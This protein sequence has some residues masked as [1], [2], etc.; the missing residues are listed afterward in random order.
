MKHINI[1]RRA[2]TLV[3]VMF[4]AL[5]SAVAQTGYTTYIDVN[6]NEQKCYNYETVNQS[7]ETLNT[8]WYLVEGDITISSG[9][10]VSGAVNLILADDANFTVN[11]AAGKAG[12]TVNEG[13]SLTIYGQANGTGTLTATGTATG[14]LSMGGGAGIGGDDMQ[15]AG[16][17]IINGGMITAT[18]NNG[19]AGIGGGANGTATTIKI[20]RGTV[21]ANGSLAAA[22]IGAGDKTE[23]VAKIGTTRYKTLTNAFADSEDND[24]IVMLKDYGN[25][26]ADED[27]NP[28]GVEEV[29]TVTK[30]VALN[31]GEY[32]LY[33]AVVIKTDEETGDEYEVSGFYVERD[34]ETP[35]VF[36][37]KGDG[38]S[39]TSTYGCLVTLVSSY[40]GVV[41]ENGCT[42]NVMENG[43]L[44]TTNDEDGLYGRTVKI[45]GGT[46]NITNGNNIIHVGTSSDEAEYTVKD[47][48]TIK[49]GIF[50]IGKEVEGEVEGS[51][52]NIFLLSKN[53]VA[54]ISNCTIDSKISNDG[55]SLIDDA[56]AT[57][58]NVTMSGIEKLFLAADDAEITVNS[59]TYSLT[60]AFYPFGEEGTI[61]LKGGKYNFDPTDPEVIGELV[62]IDPYYKSVYREEEELWEIVPKDFYQDS[63]GKYH[64]R[65][66]AGLQEFAKSVNEDENYYSGKTIVLDN[67]IVMTSVENWTPI[68]GFGGTFDGQD[69]TISGLVVNGAGDLGFFGA[70][71]GAT[72][73]NLKIS[74]A[75]I[76]GTGSN[77]AVL[78][79]AAGTS[80]IDNVIVEDANVT[81]SA[82]QYA[83]GIAGNNSSTITNSKVLNSN[84]KGYDQVGAVAGYHWCG[85][86]T[87][88]TATGN[89]VEATSERAGGLVGKIQFATGNMGTSSMS[90]N[91]NTISGTAK[92]PDFAGGITAQIMGN[93]DRYEIKNNNI[94]VTCTITDGEGG[95]NPIGCLRNGQEAAFTQVLAAKI[96]F[97]TWDEED[98]PGK[99]KGFVYS[100]VASGVNPQKIW[101]VD[102][103]VAK[104]GET[105]YLTLAEAIAA[106][107]AGQTVKI[108]KADTYTLPNIGNNITIKGDVT[109]VKFNCVGTSSISSIPNG[110]TFEN[111]EFDFGQNNYHGFQHAGTINMNGCTLNG[112]FFS[113]G[114]MNFTGCTFNQ[115]AE[116][117]HMWCYGTDVTYTNC[118]FNG[119]G[120]F[121]NVF[122]ES[123]STT[124]NITATNCTFNSTKSNKAAINVKETSDANMLKYNVVISNC[125]TNKN[126]PAG[127][128]FN[129]DETLWVIDP[130]VQVDDRN[131]TAPESGITIKL[132]GTY[133]YPVAK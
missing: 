90:I 49:D 24:E 44:I 29:I 79:G 31:I 27:G 30:N 74:G 118:E 16:T 109:G 39:I 23:A 84:I 56:V 59:G 36:T 9:I 113:Y 76:T 94:D 53:S 99:E 14:E 8:G 66:L 97:N 96:T 86:I 35:N 50:N 115:D 69:K 26:D 63:N 95:T 71:G 91:N 2:M 104:I 77:V 121:L 5:A 124:Y 51:V 130:V 131:K 25:E 129:P 7:T 72:I 21:H 102:P 122:C 68:A 22:G 80:T 18:G 108:I 45:N 19:G 67:D 82:G 83:G 33:F 81:Q 6:G 75:S 116:D 4:L 48:L 15:D 3:A 100:N 12:I 112:K 127:T 17:I 54:T 88:C 87:G 117:Y 65:N 114:V 128:A 57:L 61:T 107:T 105:K 78:V 62:R 120:K 93:C 132:N 28:D 58:N 20:N 60:E 47:T 111:V 126:F 103:Y 32:N 133:K 43:S 123:N 55:I 125:T 106:A 110:V 41:V 34:G 64:I 13:N 38:G 92:A 46:F 52:D 89:T 70:T 85:S 119:K 37:I 73:K 11:G 10:T 101:N 42:L 1:I 98:W 40:S